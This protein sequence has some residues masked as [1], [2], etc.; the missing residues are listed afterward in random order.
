MLHEPKESVILIADDQ[1]DNL[2][3]ITSILKQASPLYNFINVPNGKILVDLAQKRLPDLIIT[4]WDMPEMDGLTAIR[5]LKQ[6]P[7]TQNIPVIVCTGAM[8]GGANLKL[9]LEEGA[10]DY[11][12][13]PVDALELVARVQSM[14]KLSASYKSLEESHQTI[15]RQHYN[16]LSSVRYAL[17][18]Q[19]AILP[20]PT[21]IQRHLPDSFIFY[22][23]RDIVSGDFYWFTETTPLPIYENQILTGFKENRRIFAVIDCTGHGIPGAFMTLIGNTLLNQ[24]VKEKGT[25]E[26]ALI[27][28]ELDKRLKENLRLDQPDDEDFVKISDGMDL[29]IM[30]VGENELTWAGAKHPLIYFKAGEM[31]E[32]RGSKFPM[33]GMLYKAKTFEQHQIPFEKE[34]TFYMFTDG[35][36]DQ[37][38]VNRERL[39]SKRLR[40]ILQNIQPLAMSEQKQALEQH[41]ANWQGEE[42]Q[43]DDILVVGIRM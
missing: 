23:P 36:I 15:E 28:Q 34:D 6:S 42:K 2:Q 11:I 3:I 31:I 7:E 8:S 35:Y 20:T 30:S 38:N 41:L 22:K 24:I 32:L 25:H 14:L 40:E 17:K 29:S 18:I 12:R 43:I 39:M 26:P 16:I 10:V 19:T 33:G 21:T 13:K 4:D 5:I 9:A 1:P 37:M 27:L